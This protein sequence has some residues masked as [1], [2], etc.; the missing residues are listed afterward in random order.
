MFQ[1]E[2][3]KRMEVFKAFFE[4]TYLHNLGEIK[5][6]AFF[7]SAHLDC[8]GRACRNVYVKVSKVNK[9]NKKTSTALSSVF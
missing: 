1:V 5:I 6:L 7:V 8:K 2:K 4:V 3:C 9:Q